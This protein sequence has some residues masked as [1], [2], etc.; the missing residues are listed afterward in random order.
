MKHKIHH[1]AKR[2]FSVFRSKAM[3]IFI[4]ALL[5]V[6]D[7][8]LAYALSDPST[9]RQG[10]D[11][12]RSVF[13]KVDDAGKVTILER[14]EYGRG[15]VVHFALMKVGK[16]KKGADGKHWVE[17]DLKVRKGWKTIFVKRGLLGEGGHVTLKNDE[18]ES[19]SG[20]FTATASLKPGDYS[21]QLTVYDKVG[22]GKVR[23]RGTFTVK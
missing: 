18:A 13:A 1:H 7:I 21:M 16:F 14:G 10:L 2:V 22:G 17:S 3:L 15:E 19:P 20:V 12:E 23:D 9:F 4:V 5:V 8:F 6:G 11:F